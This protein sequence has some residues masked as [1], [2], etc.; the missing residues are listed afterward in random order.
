MSFAVIIQSAPSA[1]AIRQTAVVPFNGE[2]KVYTRWAGKRGSAGAWLPEQPAI[3]AGERLVGVPV[4]IALTEN[5][6]NDLATGFPSTLFQ[7]LVRRAGSS[8][9]PGRAFQ[10][11][12]WHP[13]HCRRAHTSSNSSDSSRS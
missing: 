12:R 7:K 4:S 1:S 2:V 6:E 9:Q 13:H 5:D 11:R 3:I 8:S 10:V